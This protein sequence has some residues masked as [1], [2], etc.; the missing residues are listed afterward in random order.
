MNA[1]MHTLLIVATV[2]LAPQSAAQNSRTGKTGSRTL[3]DGPSRPAKGACGHATCA[4]GVIDLGSS[5]TWDPT[6]E[7][8]VDGG[9]GRDRHS[10]ADPPDGHSGRMGGSYGGT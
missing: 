4:R 3:V 10:R 1:T 5:Q 6:L 8:L 9:S 2:A 7:E